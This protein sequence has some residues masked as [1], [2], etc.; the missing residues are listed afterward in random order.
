MI[1]DDWKFDDERRRALS[2][3][4]SRACEGHRYEE[5][6]DVLPILTA[7]ALMSKHGPSGSELLDALAAFVLRITLLLKSCPAAKDHSDIWRHEAM[8]RRSAAR[9]H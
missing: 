4:I 7:F 6:A 8:E 5:V 2:H 1:I 9:T 3:K